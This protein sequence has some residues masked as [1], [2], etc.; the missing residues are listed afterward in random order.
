MIRTTL[1]I[2]FVL[3]T[4]LNSF[5]QHITFSDYSKKDSRDIYFE[6]LGKFDSGYL[7]YKNIR[8]KH[9]LTRYNNDMHIV[10]NIPLDFIPDRT[11]N[12]DFV[13]YRDY[14][15]LVYQYQRNSIIYCKAARLNVANNK[16]NE[17]IELDTTRISILADNKIYTTTVS[18]DKQ[19]ILIYKRQLKNEMYTL[20]TKLYNADLTLLDSTRESMRF[21]ERRQSFSDLAVDNNGSFLFTK[22]TSRFKRKEKGSE[23][24]VILHKPGAD[25]FRNYK[26]SLGEKFI[27]DAV[28]KVDN[29]NK[30]YLINSFYYG[31]R[32]DNIEGLFTS[33][34]DING[35]HPI[36]A[37]FNP[38]TDSLRLNINSSDRSRFVF[39]NL[40]IRNTIV[41]KDGGFILSAE[42]FHTESLYNN[43]WNRRYYNGLPYVNSYDYYSSNPYYYNYRPFDGTRRD[44]TTRYYYDDVVVLSLDDS[45]RLEW[46]NIIHKKQYDVDDDNFLSF[47]NMNAGAEIHFLFL[48]KDRKRQLISNQ[49]I[50]PNGEVKRYP[51]LKTNE[52]GYGFMPRLGKQVGARQ[53][54][55]PCV[56][57]G[58]ILFAKVDF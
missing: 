46:N 38:F 15:Y 36:R 22:E 12:I 8:Q 28:I 47:T 21:D 11:F 42:D 53:M 50:L 24:E 39:D 30:H 9:V 29:L 25:S 10:E 34:I 40:V 43:S 18:E 19:K 26:L 35:E 41:K 52:T 1:L 58:Y 5:A 23:V 56:Y 16:V 6:I 17:P 27:Q 33:I 45:L 54:I 3:L 20:A 51:T 55:M 49:S 44:E 7:I 13:T 48:D 2:F 4:G 57:L 32:K 14:C 37:V 31:D